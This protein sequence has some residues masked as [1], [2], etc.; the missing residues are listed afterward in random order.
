MRGVTR[1]ASVKLAAMPGFAALALAAFAAAP[2]WARPYT[3]T[4]LPF[5]V[6]GLT[7]LGQIVGE[8]PYPQY[9][10]SNLSEIYDR[11]TITYPFGPVGIPNLIIDL[12]AINNTG[13]VIY[14][15]SSGTSNGG[16]EFQIGANLHNPFLYLRVVL[17]VLTIKVILS[18]LL[19]PGLQF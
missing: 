14:Q 10:F 13:L 2:G 6:G 3:F 4:Q 12:T 1:R 15:E 8:A 9:T 11:G 7:D 17:T 19:A 16:T 5:R 18:D